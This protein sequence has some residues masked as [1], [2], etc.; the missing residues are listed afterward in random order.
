ML[1]ALPLAVAAGL[2]VTLLTP[3]WKLSSSS[4]MLSPVVTTV[5]VPVSEP[6]GMTISTVLVV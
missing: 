5:A 6:A 2:L 1:F 3:T 4:S